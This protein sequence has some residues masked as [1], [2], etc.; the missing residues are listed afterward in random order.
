MSMSASVQS[1]GNSDSTV[2]SN[3][4]TTASVIASVGLLF[5]KFVVAR[6]Q[7]TDGTVSDP[8]NM[9]DGS[10]AAANTFTLGPGD[11]LHMICPNGYGLV[12]LVIQ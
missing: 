12:G 9:V 2:Y 4:S 8:T 6:I 3:S 7:H 11:S 10:N 5:G 1:F